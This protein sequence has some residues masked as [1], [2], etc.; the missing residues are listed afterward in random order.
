MA[1]PMN[2]GERDERLTIA[3]RATDVASIERGLAE[4]WRTAPDDSTVAGPVTRACMSNLIIWSEKP[5]NAAGIARDVAT[6]LE[7]HPAR[8][9]LLLPNAGDLTTDVE[10]YVS[11]QCHLGDSGRQVCSE[12]ITVSARPGATR[13]LPSVARPLLIGDL[14][15]VLWWTGVDPPPYADA[16]FEDLAAMATRVIYDSREWNQPA[17]SLAATAAWAAKQG[18]MRTADLAWRRLEPWRR[19]VAE[20]LDPRRLPQALPAIR[21]VVITHGPHGL[22]QALLLMAWLADRLGWQP[23]QAKITPNVETQWTFEAANAPVR[24]IIRRL[25]EGDTDIQTVS[26]TWGVRREEH[27]AV[28]THATADWLVASLDTSAEP[29][30]VAHLAPASPA[31]LVA[32]QLLEL[33]H[34]PVFEGALRV[35]ARLS[36]RSAPAGDTTLHDGR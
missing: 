17:S 26:V 14:P 33:R 29:K 31:R 20:V 15:T 32:Q 16:A 12:S 5:A 19:L 27:H 4:L 28:L 35:T 23:G 22:S 11:A 13:R 18:T 2:P 1:N 3:P 9:L 7:R 24:A 10:A 6:I 34:D 8:V 30:H 21:S 36:P 25:D